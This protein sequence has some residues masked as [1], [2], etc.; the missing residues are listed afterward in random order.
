[1]P[2][3]ADLAAPG[4]PDVDAVVTREAPPARRRPR[5]SRRMRARAD[6]MARVLASSGRRPRR[7]LSSVA[8]GG[9]GIALGLDAQRA[10]QQVA[11]PEIP[12]VPAERTPVDTGPGGHGGTTTTAGTSLL[13]AA[14]D[15]DGTAAR[16]TAEPSAAAAPRA[17]RGAPA[18][19]ARPRAT[20]P[21]RADE[22]TSSTSTPRS[23]TS[24]RPSTRA[25]DPDDP[26]PRGRRA[27]VGSRGIGDLEPGSGS[28]GD[29]A[30][31]D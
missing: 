11:L 18:T 15:G 12:E 10:G 21:T 7:G 1:V 8:G 26:A 3:I 2:A 5:P 16:R 30:T 25:E 17:T 28:G 13:D 31:A 20:A 4:R 24:V 6:E 14:D 22:P 29:D 9:V 27:T 19:T 23:T